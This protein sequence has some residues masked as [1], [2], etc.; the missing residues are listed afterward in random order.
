M[1]WYV[2]AGAVASPIAICVSA[3][4][5]A[6]V[7]FHPRVCARLGHEVHMDRHPDRFGEMFCSRCKTV[8]SRPGRPADG[9]AQ[10]KVENGVQ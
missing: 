8:L 2:L 10:S 6:R 7:M 4:A 9:A 1:W 3:I 5:F